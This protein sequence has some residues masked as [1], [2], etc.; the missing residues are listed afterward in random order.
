M[1][2]H[3]I[4]GGKAMVKK[5][6][7]VL[8]LVIV[9]VLGYAATKPDTFRVE[10]KAVIP[11]PPEQVY[12]LIEDFHRWGEWSPWEKLDPAMARTHGGPGK[13]LG[14]TY[15]WKGNSDVGEGRMEITEATPPARIVIKLDFIDPFESSNVTV[16]SLVPKDGGT[17]VTWSMDGP[18][19]YVS[20]LMDTVVGM[21]RMIG[22]DFEQ[23]LANMKDAAAG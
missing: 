3:P 12:A 23:G 7:L 19:P 18:M 17:E 4:L 13:G 9:G 10:R 16:F 5:I 21:D 14:A 15:A 1:P 20:K 2:G 8:L 11:A 6:L 22:K